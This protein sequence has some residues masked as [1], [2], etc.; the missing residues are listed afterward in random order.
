[1]KGKSVETIDLKLCTLLKR[2]N[3][4]K[5]GMSWSGTRHVLLMY[6]YDANAILAE[7]LNSRSR[8][9][10]LEAYTR[11]AKH[12]TNKGYRPRVRWLDNEESE[13]L[14]GYN[15]QEDIGYE[16]VPPQIHCVNVAERAIKNGRT[17]LSR[18]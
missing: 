15:R 18:E 5:K 6:V 16:L 2:D 11:Q 14:S 9:H 13:I 12:L 10:I 4:Q 7:P 3:V 8:S 1:M 17:N